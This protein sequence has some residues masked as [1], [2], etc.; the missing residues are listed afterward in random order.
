MTILSGTGN[1]T[2][3]TDNLSGP[4]TIIQTPAV[5]GDSKT[6]SVSK[7]SGVISQDS[8]TL[9]YTFTAVT[10]LIVTTPPP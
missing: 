10:A 5:D 8:V 3:Q 9:T 1:V 7:G 6:G 4:P 2:A